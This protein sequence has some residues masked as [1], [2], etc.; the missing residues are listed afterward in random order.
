MTDRQPDE[1]GTTRAR[2]GAGGQAG[3]G[4]YEV[5]GGLTGGIS[6][7]Q[8]LGGA[9]ALAAGL[10]VPAWPGITDVAFAAGDEAG[11][12]GAELPS[13]RPNIVILMTDQERYPQHWPEGWARE[14]LPNRQRLARHGLTFRRAFCAASMCSPSRASIF[15]GLYPAEH[16]VTEVLQYG[17]KADETSQHTLHPSRQNIGKL[18]ESAGYNVQYRGKW[19]MSKDPSGTLAVQSR[20]DLERYHVKGWLTPDAGGDESSAM[21]GG[22][23]A[24]YDRLTAEQAAA[25]LRSADPRSARPFALVVSLVNPHDVMG[26]PKTWFDPSYSDIKPYHGSG[27]YADDYPGCVDQDIELPSTWDEAPWDNFKPHC[28]WQ[29]TEMWSVGLKPIVDPQ[30]MREYVN[31]YAYLHRRSD[32]DMGLVLDA[33]EANGD[34]HARTIVIRL[35]DHGEMGL[36]HGGMRE[37]AYNAYEET[38][39]VPLVVS[40]PVLFPRAVRTDALASTVDLFPTLA[41]LADAPR[42]GRWTFRGRD[43]TPVVRDAVRHPGKPTRRVQDSVVYTTD[44]TIGSKPGWV[45]DDGIVKQP[46]HIRA[47]REKRYKFAMYFDPEHAYDPLYRQYELYDLDEDPHELHNMADPANHDWYDRDKVREMEQKLA[48]RMADTHTTP[49][50]GPPGAPPA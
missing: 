26:C 42:P 18:L 15:T 17:D 49:G 45:F 9:A 6:R 10:A 38:M 34:L 35:S 32:E 20:R 30:T 39:H 12:G 19:H 37:K 36:A 1:Q 48:A 47:I 8:F 46:A 11:R 5:T 7:R 43:L 29:S 21:F 25:F 33:L 41:S 23:T 28:Q 31:F 16:G 14:N 3:A 40:N 27:N 13:H 50:G 24:D 4:A 22:G 2:D 44:E